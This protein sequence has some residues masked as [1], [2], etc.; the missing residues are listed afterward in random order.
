MTFYEAL[1]KVID[2]KGLLWA[3]PVGTKGWGITIKADGY[4]Y[5]VP[6][7]TGGIMANIPSAKELIS[8]WETI[9]PNVY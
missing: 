1:L 9:S 7:I 2:T 3:R 4:F 8:N 5:L 6:T